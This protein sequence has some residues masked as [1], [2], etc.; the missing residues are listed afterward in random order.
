MPPHEQI[1]IWTT[2]HQPDEADQRRHENIKAATRRYLMSLAA[3]TPPCAD[4]TAA[5]RYARMAMMTAS[6]AVACQPSL[7]AHKDDD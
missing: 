7:D 6:A 1:R 3:N 4:R 2:Y 5:F